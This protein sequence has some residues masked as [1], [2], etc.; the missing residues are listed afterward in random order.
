M[1]QPSMVKIAGAADFV[2]EP[3]DENLPSTAELIAQAMVPRPEEPSQ[4][5]SKDPASSASSKPSSPG[6]SVSDWHLCTLADAYEPL[7]GPFMLSTVSSKFPAS[8]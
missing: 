5:E 4:L 2:P 7:H 8:T 1:N 3:V 6:T